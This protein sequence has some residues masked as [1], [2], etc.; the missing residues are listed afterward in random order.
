MSAIIFVLAS[1]VA[2]TL[3]APTPTCVPPQTQFIWKVPCDG[4]SFTNRIAVSNVT[5]SQQGKPIDQLGGLDVSIPLDLVAT[6][7]DQYGQISKPLIDVSIQEYSK[8]LFGSCQWNKMPTLGLLDNLDSCKMVPNCHLTGSP[9]SLPASIDIKS[10]AG[11]LYAGLNV[12]TYYGLSLTFKDDK[13]P[14]LCV[15]AQGLVLKK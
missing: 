1:M 9:T 14:V 15:Y 2:L 6:I 7:N 5:G 12:N 4:Q 11:P 10:I 8:S 13:T 3:A